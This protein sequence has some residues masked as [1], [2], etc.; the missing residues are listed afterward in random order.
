MVFNRFSL[1]KYQT[2]FF[3]TSRYPKVLLEKLNHIKV[4]QFFLY[5]L[6][7]RVLSAFGGFIRLGRDHA[8]L[9]KIIHEATFLEKLPASSLSYNCFFFITLSLFETPS[10]GQG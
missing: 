3:I 2:C 9:K 1:A 6:L 8:V 5:E 7:P 10:L 4:T